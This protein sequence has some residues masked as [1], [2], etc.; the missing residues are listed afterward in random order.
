[1]NRNLCLLLVGAALLFSFG[2]AAKGPKFEPLT[3]IPE[4]KSLIYVYRPSGFV[5]GGVFYDVYVGQEK[6]CELVQGGYCSTLVA[7]GEVEVWAKTESKTSLTLDAKANDVNYVKGG[8]SMGFLV[9]RPHLELVSKDV[10]ASEIAACN[11]CV[12]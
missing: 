4:G 7:P 11:Q 5:G 8:I 10:G 1:M 2:C 3:A 6:I 12:K 9:G